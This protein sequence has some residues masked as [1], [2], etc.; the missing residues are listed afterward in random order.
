ML[1]R[2]VQIER[3]ARR[4]SNW[5]QGS[6]RARDHIGARRLQVLGH[7]RVFNKTR[8]SSRCRRRA[9]T[10]H[11]RRILIAAAGQNGIGERTLFA[12]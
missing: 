10:G 2:A 6:R 5:R 8:S 9:V 1:Q 4:R 12:C 3:W 11:D 7:G